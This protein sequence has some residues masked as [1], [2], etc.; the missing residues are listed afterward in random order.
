MDR[1]CRS[2]ATTLRLPHQGTFV[3][4]AARDFPVLARSPSRTRRM[5]CAPGAFSPPGG[6]LRQWRSSS[7]SRV[8]WS[9]HTPFSD[10]EP[11]VARLPTNSR[12]MVTLLDMLLYTVALRDPAAGSQRSAVA[13]STV[14]HHLGGGRPLR[15]ERQ[16][17]NRVAVDIFAMRI[18]LRDL[19][20]IQ[21][22]LTTV[23]RGSTGSR[24]RTSLAW[25][26]GPT[27]RLVNRC[28]RGVPARILAITRQTS[29]E[30]TGLSR[31]SSRRMAE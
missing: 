11:R 22:S 3:V 2:C 16:F 5:R 31:W 25:W 12:F 1:G 23:D 26:V 7:P 14:G 9:T 8:V 13:A 6:W 20:A 21:V 17:M 28:R 27:R 15:Q 4:V 29:P 30:S 18:C 24:P 19:S 10:R